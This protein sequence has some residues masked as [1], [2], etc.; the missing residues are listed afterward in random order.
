MRERALSSVIR[1]ARR[2]A[3][4]AL[5]VA[6]ATACADLAP[7][8][9]DR[10][11]NAVLEEAHEDCDRYAGTQG[12]TCAPP[13]TPHECRYIC[14]RAN[15]AHPDC[16]IGWG[17]GADQVCRKSSG[18][19][20]DLHDAVPFPSLRQLQ[21]GDFDGDGMREILALSKVDNFGRRFARI[22]SPPGSVQKARA[23]ALSMLI[24]VPAVGPLNDD[25]TE[26]IAFADFNGVSVLRG[27]IDGPP[28]AAV[29]P[30]FLSDE[31]TLL[32]A[33][34]IDVLPTGADK[35]VTY[36]F[37]A[38]TASASLR[39]YDNIRGSG[40]PLA[41]I[42]G[43][44]KELVGDIVSGRFD[45]GASCPDLV[46]PFSGASAVTLVT[47]CR[48]DAKGAPTWR[49]GATPRSIALPSDAKLEVGVRLVDLDLDGHLD[50]LVGGSITDVSSYLYAAW[51]RG[52]GTF[53]SMP[54]GEG[55][56]DTAGKYTLPV[57]TSSFPLAITDL[58][59]DKTADFVVAEGVYISDKSDKA[60]KDG[61]RL[62]YRNR[63]APWTMASV[64]DLNANVLPDVIAGSANA[65]DLD[66][67]NNA[68]GGVL[69]PSIVATI[70][71]PRSLAI[72]D[73]DGDLI[74]DVAYVEEIE[75]LD[76]RSNQ[77]E[78]AYGSPYGPPT[79]ASLVARLEPVEQMHPAHLPAD[80]S[81][82]DP[83]NADGL[84]DLVIV[85]HSGE[86]SLDTLFMLRGTGSRGV[87][88]ALPLQT[89]TLSQ[90]SLPLGFAIGRFDKSGVTSLAALGLDEAN[91]IDTPM[92]RLWHIEA[93]E[94]LTQGYLVASAALSSK[95]HAGPRS[96]GGKVAGFR[97]GAAM[98]AGDI[99]HD[100]IDEIV[101]AAPFDTPDGAALVIARPDPM[102]SRFVANEEVVLPTAAPL[103]ADSV[104]SLFDIDGD[105]LPEALLSTGKE[106]SPGDALVLWNDHRGGLDVRG[107]VTL[108]IDGGVAGFA[109]LPSSSRKGC[110]PLLTSRSGTYLVD[111]GA[112][113]ELKPMKRADLP[114]GNAIAVG[115]FDGD[116]VPD[117]A[118][119]TANTD[120]VTDA[121]L[122]FR[123]K[124]GRE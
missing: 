48:A 27:R 92:L 110:D 114:A 111:G 4:G 124:P 47:P 42:T 51:G 116:G 63:G 97:Y 41:T 100:G 37:D 32:R 24:S 113:P 23:Q 50:L 3:F 72:G 67:L 106:G 5:L 20:E 45:E 96:D 57:K 60:D 61:Y 62:A 93:I 104:L 66:F 31:G 117:V 19:F 80:E 88:T 119:A 21:I 69:N 115:D 36:T 73:F 25:P 90:P 77:V 55:T 122:F 15:D 95:F 52:D 28:E 84:S 68:G 16:P 7:I 76:N 103:S 118:I 34:P 81:S 123:S 38:K 26:D 56:A 85:S 99:D 75:S 9:P 1:A 40:V 30:S 86:T 64:A 59:A 10:C 109:C 13:G 82:R 74:N 58:N 44:T 121:V 49:T 79:A 35:I 54:K 12:G 98:T 65:L 87:T 89:Q 94:G 112:A 105:G 91:A 33:L 107:A 120:A 14:S 11:G 43:A 18:V 70:G 8:E 53:T 2:C 46:F 22:I 71:P 39:G 29:F 102:T 108:H 6:S 17:C 78:I 101:L 83:S